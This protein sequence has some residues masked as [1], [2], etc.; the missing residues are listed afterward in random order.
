VELRK[1]GT[2]LRWSPQSLAGLVWLLI[3]RSILN[4]KAAKGAK[5]D[6]VQSFAALGVQTYS[7]PFPFSCVPH[8]DWL[9]QSRQGAKQWARVNRYH[10]TAW[11]KCFLKLIA[12]AQRGGNRGEIPFSDSALPCFRD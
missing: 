7:L 3:T 11:S 2:D 8:S 4:T 12:E 1:A 10:R 9:T 6:P 5:I